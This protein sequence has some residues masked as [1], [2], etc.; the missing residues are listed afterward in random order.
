MEFSN[1]WFTPHK[2][3]W[4]SLISRHQ[5]KRILEIG[6]YEGQS[7]CFLMELLG[8]QAP[9]EIYC[10]DTWEGGQEHAG[11]DM[12]A[13]EHRFDQNI[14][15]AIQSTGQQHQVFKIKG[16]SSLGLASLLSQG[17]GNYFDMV[18]IDGSH[19]TPDVFSDAALA[20]RL[21]RLG[22]LL[23]FD[24]YVWG[25][26]VNADPIMNPK[27]AIDSFLNCYQRKVQVIP[28]MPICQM[29]CQKI[30]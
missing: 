30:G 15:E 2:P 5:P 22:G 11:Y 3:A 23:I 14:G 17:K 12:S 28:W 25:G 10:L 27:M 8:N 13:V 26:G 4:T 18:Y 6:S 24:D 1:D 9:L 29:Y 16:D 20:Y 19:E 21:L 7:I